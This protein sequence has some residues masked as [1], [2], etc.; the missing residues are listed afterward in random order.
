MCDGIAAELQ[1]ISL[2]DKR[3][4]K[5]SARIIEL[6][7]ADP[8]ASVNAACGGWGDTFAA[9]RFFNNSKVEPNRILQP[10]VEATKRRM[11]EH[12]VVLIAQDTT[13]LDFSLHPPDDAGCL[14]TEDRL[15]L[16]DHTHLAITP[17]RLCLGVV[18]AEQFDRTPESLGKTKKRKNL[19]I[20][21]KES[22][23]WLTGYRLASKLAGECPD[24]RIV[25]VADS[26]ADIYDIFLE[27]EH[28]PTP[29]DFLIR[30]KEDRS[31]PER[32]LDSGP[33]VYRKVRDEVSVSKVLIR[34]T[35]DL[36]QTPKRAARK[37]ELEIRAIRVTVK[38]PHARS[39]LPT[40]T[41]NVVLVE[42]VNGPQDGTD[43]SWLLLT[44]LPIDSTEDVLRVIDYYVA[45]WTIEVYFRV[46]KTGCRVEAIQLETT[47]R[48]KNCLA[49]Y[50]I[51]AW[52]VMYLTYLNRECPSLPCTAVFDDCEWKSVWHVT[53]KQELPKTPP[54]LSEFMPLLA[55]LGGYNN[56]PS[57]PPPGP[58]M[59][60]VGIRRMTDFAI[61]W[62]AF[63]PDQKPHMYN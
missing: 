50:K 19:P 9:Y 23:R 44:T 16:Y 48:I 6:L 47:R 31:T 61:A 58:Q 41:M 27:A 15:G 20:E 14:N 25:S 13:E 30:A 11:K 52:R 45:R 8:A 28:H 54:A 59:I 40:V 4:N 24:T 46:F 2:G 18:G 29:A 57:E 51:I 21:E 53:T 38:P 5:R 35:V 37:A 12:P 10:H 49:F 1:G 32:D 17:E 60:W 62:Q 7:G 26:E 63:G 22:F 43:V 36:P 34:K 56:R 42:E 3:L 39:R 55:Q 33:A